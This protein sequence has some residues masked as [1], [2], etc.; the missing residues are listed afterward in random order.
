MRSRRRG[1]LGVGEKCLGC[2]K[3]RRARRRELDV[4]RLVAAA[5]ATLL[6]RMVL[7]HD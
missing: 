7:A 2:A 4:G 3:A 5:P 6:V 1:L